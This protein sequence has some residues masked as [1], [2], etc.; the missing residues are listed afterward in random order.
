MA[1]PRINSPKH[2]DSASNVSLRRVLVF[3]FWIVVALLFI[4]S[5]FKLRSDQKHIESPIHA[6]NDFVAQEEKNTVAIESKC[7]AIEGIDLGLKDFIE[8]SFP[9]PT[10]EVL[11]NLT[12]SKGIIHSQNSNT[13]VNSIKLQGTVDNLSKTLSTLYFR[14]NEDSIL[15]LNVK[16]IQDN[17]FSS[18]QMNIQVTPVIDSLQKEVSLLIKTHERPGSLDLLVNSIRQYYPTINVLI[19]DDSKKPTYTTKQNNI[20]YFPL[21]YDFGLSASRNYLVEQSTTPY[22]MSLDDDF[23]FTNAT[24][25][26]K[27]YQFLLNHGEFDLASGSLYTDTNS[28]LYDYAGLINIEGDNFKL[29][30]GDRGIIIDSDNHCKLVDIV[31]NFFMAKR[32]KLNQ[33][34]WDPIL[35]L[36]EHQDFFLRAKQESMK[37]AACGDLVTVFHK[38]DHSNPEYKQ[39]RG[40]E[41]PFIRKFLKKHNLKN[42]VLYSGLTW[43]YTLD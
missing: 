22:V 30:R 7:V 31:A 29:V 37:V 12:V 3:S 42:F 13:G 4:N 43:V 20:K 14:G 11:L 17:E 16:S 26:E 25:I 6:E 9:N 27:L 1:K 38:Q 5:Y 23:V 15:Y 36:G 32:D 33:V 40:R 39:K 2:H 19:G 28:E 34:K 41:V 21:E 18:H 8:F 10:T 35:K 24:K